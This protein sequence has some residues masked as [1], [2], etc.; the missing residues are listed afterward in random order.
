M[1]LRAHTQ[2]HDAEAVRLAMLPLA[3]VHAPPGEQPHPVPRAL[4]RHPRAHVH[5]LRAARRARR[6]QPP[7][8]VGLAAA[9]FALVPC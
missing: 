7:A 8:P 9:P 2:L 5:R 1:V 4:T 3:L 6:Q